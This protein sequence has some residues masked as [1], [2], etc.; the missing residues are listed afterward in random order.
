M[1]GRSV[2]RDSVTEML[3]AGGPRVLVVTGQDGMGVRFSLRLL[4]RIVGTQTPVVE[5][6]AGDLDRLPPRD[7][8]SVLVNQLGLSVA[9]PMPDAMPD[10]KATEDIPRWIRSDLAPWFQKVL[11]EEQAR[12][13]SR[14]PAWKC[15]TINS[16]VINL[17]DFIILR[18]SIDRN[19]GKDWLAPLVLR[20]TK[21][22]SRD[23]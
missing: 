10:A 13:P 11:S 19:L 2:F 21:H 5:I 20:F 14:F 9:R 3:A 1:I 7:F 16:T 22:A 17:I 18:S 15:S 6:A 12:G 8:L 23:Q 4:R